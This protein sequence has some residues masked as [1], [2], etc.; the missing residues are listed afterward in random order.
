M[1][2]AFW[3]FVF[4]AVYPYALYPLLLMIL[5]RLFPRPS[6]RDA[7]VAGLSATVIVSAHNEE[8]V[9]ER[10]LRTTLDSDF[11][12]ANLKVLVVSDA[13]TD[14]T[15]EIVADMAQQSSLVTLLALDQHGGKTAGLNAAMELVD[16]DVVVFTDANA[17]FEGPALARLLAP[18]TDPGVGYVVG[19]AEYRSKETSQAG[20]SEGLY[21]KLELAQKTLESVFDS[22]VG[23]DGAIYAIRRGL[24]QPLAAED[25][26]DFVNPLQIIAQGYRGLFVTDARAFEEPAHDYRK[27][28][29]RRRRIVCRTWGAF[30]RY[31]PDLRLHRFPRFL[32]MLLSHKVIRWF[33]LLWLLLALVLNLCLIRAG[34]LYEFTAAAFALN[35]ALAGLGWRQ[36]CSGRKVTRTCSIPYYFVL[37]NLAALMGIFDYLRGNRY[38]TWK[39]VRSS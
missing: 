23:G 2:L 32:F 3:I 26:N 29:R 34:T 31:G 20:E 36:A 13:S 14:G 39:H 17:I 22:V 35:F 33:T 27:E 21:W 9:I 16:T 5:A 30:L 19:A 6:A 15:N 4:L 18:F 24:Y 28:F 8:A 25:I 12:Q 38:V 1:Q 10:K 37:S 7:R 11:P